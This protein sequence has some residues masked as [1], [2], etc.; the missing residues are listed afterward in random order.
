MRQWIMKVVRFARAYRQSQISES[1]QGGKFEERLG[2]FRLSSSGNNQRDEEGR[3]ETE[4]RAD[5][6]PHK[7]A[8]L[9][10][11]H[12]Q[13]GQ[14]YDHGHQKAE[15]RGGQSMSAERAERIAQDNYSAD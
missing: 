8:D 15:S 11:T 12:S 3:E 6:S 2:G 5:H 14:Q 7:P 10:A 4:D 9:R 13:F 1:K